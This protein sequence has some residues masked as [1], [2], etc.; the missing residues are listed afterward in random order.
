MELA[1][2][3]YFILVVLSAPLLFFIA[4]LLYKRYKKNNRNNSLYLSR[5]FFIFGIGDV[6]LILEQS[7][8]SSVYG[9]QPII[10]GEFY[11][12]LARYIVCL[13][14]FMVAFGLW[15]LNAFSLD[16]LP[17]KYHNWIWIIGPL[18]FIHAIL[19]YI[20]PY[21]W[22]LQSAIYEFAHDVEP[23][24][25]PVLI[26][27]YLT[28]VWLSPL[29]LLFATYRIRNE[30][31]FVKV[32]SLTISL[33]LIVGAAGYSIQVVAPSILSGLGFF[34]FPIIA[35]MGLVMPIWY[36]ELWNINQKA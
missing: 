27:F 6:L 2:I 11:E 13:A 7:I 36:R 28:P 16:F 22:Y 30:P 14:I 8:L 32:K 17:E 5:A 19:Y 1:Q 4:Y 35:Y 18:G 9:T 25:S 29:I 34:L 15:Y 24:Q 12:Q 3:I 31:R 10:K 21:N 33:G 23:W 26:F 20:F